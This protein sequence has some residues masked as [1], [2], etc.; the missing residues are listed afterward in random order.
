MTRVIIERLTAELNPALAEPVV[1]KW[2]DAIGSIAAP[3]SADQFGAQIKRDP[4]RYGQVV[5]AAG[6][7]AE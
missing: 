6:I 2:L 5:K 3:G 4:E 7:K 1:I